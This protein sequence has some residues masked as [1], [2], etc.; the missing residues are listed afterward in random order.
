METEVGVKKKYS[1]FSCTKGKTQKSFG[2]SEGKT[3]KKYGRRNQ[4]EGKIGQSKQGYGFNQIKAKLKNT[5]EVWI[6]ATIFVANLVKFAE[7]YNFHF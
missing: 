3:Q 4:I 1:T 7:L 5:A 6:G 2:L